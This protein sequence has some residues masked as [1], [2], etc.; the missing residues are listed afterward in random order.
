[1]TTPNIAPILTSDVI[2]KDLLGLAARLARQNPLP[3]D[4]AEV[5]APLTA[6]LLLGQRAGCRMPQLRDNP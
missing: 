2:S 4:L 3:V 5:V 1:M 6:A